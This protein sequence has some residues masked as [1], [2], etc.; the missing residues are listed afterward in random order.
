M[1]SGV[2]PP[3]PNELLMKD[4]LDTLIEELKAQYDYN[5]IDSAPV[6]SVSDTFLLNR[7]TDI[8][9]YVCRAN[10]SDKRNI[11]YVNKVNEEKSLKQIYLIVN[12][13]DFDLKRYSNH[14]YG[15]G[16]GKK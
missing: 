5:I 6:G 4:R 8:T 11:D 16:Y 9:M 13:V 15:Y 3:N 2:I 10:Y 1:P 12:D 7:I 14:G